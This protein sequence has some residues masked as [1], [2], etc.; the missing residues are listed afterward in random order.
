MK[1]TAALILG[2]LLALSL[3]TAAMASD[4]DKMQ[5]EAAGIDIRVPEEL[6][7]LEGYLDAYPIGVIDEDHHSYAA[8][9]YYIGMPYDDAENLLNASDRTE[10]DTAELKSGMFYI[11]PVLATDSDADKALQAFEDVFSDFEVD[12]DR[13]QE[14]GNADGYTFY[15]VPLAADEY[16]SKIGEEYAEECGK[17]EQAL[18]EAEKKADFYAPKDA[19]KD[20]VGQKISFTTTDIDGNTVT[21]EELFAKNEI[22]MLNFWGTWC[23]FCM[24]EMDELAQIHKNLQKKGCGIVG[25]EYESTPDEETYNYGR[26]YLEE[27]GV[28]YPNVIMPE[29]YLGIVAGFP[30]SI[31]V[32]KE[33]KV[34]TMPI[35][36]PRVDKYEQTIDELL[37]EM[38]A[39]NAEANNTD[40]TEDTEGTDSTDNT[41]SA[42]N[43]AAGYSVTVT[44]EDGPVEGVVIQFCD[45]NTCSMKPTDADGIASLEDADGGDYEI[46]VLVVP[47]GYKAD[48]TVYHF[49]GGSSMEIK[50]EKAA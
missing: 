35:G 13:M 10:D 16:Y 33:G 45:D 31:L 8:A 9:F 50:L 32:D 44:D 49:D 17:L 43:A 15:S 5:L 26:E 21:S 29:E 3:S 19:E 1:K 6:N 39:G 12:R 40:N 46:H 27:C 42:V 11:A 24:D 34:L 4:D 18:I 41:A 30:T 2:S 22:T 38:K 48:E 14:L 36:G 37:N 20:M 23:P 28:E 47:D 25:L 7:S